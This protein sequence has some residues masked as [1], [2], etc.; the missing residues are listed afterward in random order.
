MSQSQFQQQQRHH[1]HHR[2]GGFPRVNHNTNVVGLGYTPPASSSSIA[3]ATATA[4]ATTAPPN[5]YSRKGS[6]HKSSNSR[7]IYSTPVGTQS[8]ASKKSSTNLHGNSDGSG[9]PASPPES[10]RRDFSGSGSGIPS[11]PSLTATKFGGRDRK[12]G[13]SRNNSSVDNK[14]K[15]EMF[16]QMARDRLPE[17]T[18]S[19]EDDPFGM[20][21]CSSSPSPPPQNRLPKAKT[22]ASPSTTTTAGSGGSR[23]SRNDSS[24]NS[25]GGGNR[26][27]MVTPSRSNSPSRLRKPSMG[28]LS[29]G[30]NFDVSGSSN[31]RSHPHT[32]SATNTPYH[33]SGHN[34]N[35]SRELRR[36]T[37]G[38][39]STVRT[40]PPSSSS[41]A[42][43]T[44]KSPGTNS[45]SSS[46]G[47]AKINSI[48]GG[49]GS[50]PRVPDINYDLPDIDFSAIDDPFKKR[51]KIP[52]KSSR[53]R[54]E[55]AI[56]TTNATTST[57]TSKPDDANGGGL[58]PPANNRIVSAGS[59]SINSSVLNRLSIFSDNSVENYQTP[60]AINENLNPS[61]NNGK[62]VDSKQEPWVDN[63]KQA[64]RLSFNKYRSTTTNT[65]SN[66]QN[67]HLDSVVT[68]SRDDANN[69]PPPP[70]QQ[71]S[72][73]PA[74]PIKQN[75]AAKSRQQ[76]NLPAVVP[77]PFQK[78]DLIPM[79]GSKKQP[80]PHTHDNFP[81]NDSNEDEDIVDYEALDRLSWDNPSLI[82]I[83]QQ[84]HLSSLLPH[85]NPACNNDDG[86]GEIQDHQRYVDSINAS[87][88]NGDKSKPKVSQNV[89]Y[90]PQQQ[91]LLSLKQQKQNQQH[92]TLPTATA[93]DNSTNVGRTLPGDPSPLRNRVSVA[94][95]SDMESVENFG[96]NSNTNNGSI[97]NLSGG[98]VADPPALTS[99]QIHRAHSNQKQQQPPYQYTTAGNHSNSNNNNNNYPKLVGNITM[100]GN[101]VNN[102]GSV[103]ASAAVSSFGTKP[104][105]SPFVGGGMEDVAQR[106]I[107]E[108]AGG[109]GYRQQ[110]NEKDEE[111]GMDEIYRSASIA[112]RRSKAK[113]LAIISN[114]NNGG[115]G[116]SI[117]EQQESLPQS[118]NKALPKSDATTNNEGN[119]N[120]Q[121]EEEGDNEYIPFDR[122]LIP[123][124]FKRIRKLYQTSPEEF[125]QLSAETK[126]RFRISEKWYEREERKKIALMMSNATLGT[127]NIHDH[128]R[129]GAASGRTPPIS[130]SHDQQQQLSPSVSSAAA[131]NNGD[132]INKTRGSNNVTMGGGHYQQPSEQIP[133]PLAPA[134]ASKSSSTIQSAHTTTNNN[135][136]GSNTSTS[137]RSYY[138]PPPRLAVT[139]VRK[140]YQEINVHTPTPMHRFEIHDS[141]ATSASPRHHHHKSYPTRQQQQQIQRKSNKKSSSGAACCCTIM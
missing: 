69:R 96:F 58:R 8:L 28:K 120:K 105:S 107:S 50:S 26:P 62:D 138:N 38:G 17:N 108:G 104:S 48:R 15:E 100:P 82:P 3:A 114:S 76:S 25:N 81:E 40:P 2:G 51:D 132:S 95:S 84:N 14:N 5:N 122:V 140:E 126:E 127:T 1:H 124:S 141:P 61:N 136:N 87:L 99:S 90:Q 135:T 137:G 123:T 29:L 7:P 66:A 129:N 133:S 19:D 119:D 53:N 102:G 70:Y 56:T 16:M 111:D 9:F 27:W 10:L 59:T 128:R 92:L 79:F 22:L 93:N 88:D 52:Q 36:Q 134:A 94:N 31:S 75:T 86:G 43:N 20:K 37:E 116:S 18:F 103:S 45:R 34:K 54:V 49:G 64:R 74:T 118:N 85:D 24:S 83:E 67:H 91:S 125:D 101:N 46:A 47:P 23:H 33:G 139:P 13:H 106:S 109:G 4:T 117:P 32:T 98:G 78:R 72:S 89:H 110:L 39:S 113:P 42:L 6:H 11:P 55:D 130:P 77:T 63:P 57:N 68:N 80:S 60:A 35:S 131:N 41:S 65:T 121:G 73:A 112:S 30:G 21:P 97:G 71:V 115:G 12:G 44:K